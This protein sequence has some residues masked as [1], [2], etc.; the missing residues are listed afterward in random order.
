M[1]LSLRSTLLFDFQSFYKVL[2]N[3][4]FNNNGEFQSWIRTKSHLSKNESGTGIDTCLICILGID[5]KI[6]H[7]V[8][9]FKS[10]RHYGSMKGFYV[11]Y[12]LHF[13]RLLYGLCFV[14]FPLSIVFTCL[15][16]R[17]IYCH[18]MNTQLQ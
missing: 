7:S 2:N 12:S 11:K 13:S 16:Q 8:H 5:A 18:R 3:H 10:K 9:A 6:A 15:N 4:F 1:G 14:L 17:K